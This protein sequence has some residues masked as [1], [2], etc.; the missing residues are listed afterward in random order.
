M[1]S[2]M[3]LVPAPV[4]SPPGS[5][6]RAEVGQVRLD[7]AVQQGHR[8]P[9]PAGQRPDLRPD[10]PG[11]EPPF[12][13]LDR[14]GWE[15]RL[16]RPARRDGHGAGAGAVRA[17]I[18]PAAATTP[19]ASA[20]RSP[21]QARA[22]ARLAARPGSESRVRPAA[23]PGAA[24]RADRC[25]RIAC[26]WGPSRRG[27]PDHTPICGGAVSAWPS[28][29]SVSSAIQAWRRRS[30]SRLLPP[31]PPHREPGPPGRFLPGRVGRGPVGAH[32]AGY[33]GGA[34]GARRRWLGEAAVG[35][36]PRPRP[37]A[38]LPGS[39]ARVRAARRSSRRC[40]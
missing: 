21:A 14:L 40:R 35:E 23:R 11:G 13:R 5:T 30:V 1:S 36:A 34:P 26:S 33:P 6:A 20:R 19:A 15:G 32:E 18:R 37:S 2:V 31:A 29:T 25:A 9:G 3:P 12:E 24:S 38:K 17:G 10:I 8:D 7:P 4:V 28:Q 16:G 27:S 39:A 22:R